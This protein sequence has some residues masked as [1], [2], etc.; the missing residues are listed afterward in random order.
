MIFQKAP[1]KAILICEHKWLRKIKIKGALQHAGRNKNLY[2]YLQ[3]TELALTAFYC[4][5]EDTRQK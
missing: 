1:V 5:Q 4:R 3:D 2:L